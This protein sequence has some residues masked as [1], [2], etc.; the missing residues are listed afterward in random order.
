VH[1]LR[2]EFILKASLAQPSYPGTV[3]TA[4]NVTIA[5]DGRV[6]L[7]DRP[8]ADSGDAQVLGLKNWLVETR[9]RF[10]DKDPVII[11]PA[12]TVPHA[13]VMEVLG[14]VRAAQWSTV[15]FR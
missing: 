2:E 12:P 14:A 6:L 9:Q 8:I 4:I 1:R 11:S 3:A 5:E 7:M 10:G 13:R 15:T